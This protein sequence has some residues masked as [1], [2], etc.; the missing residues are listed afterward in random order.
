MGLPWRRMQLPNRPADVRTLSGR[1]V[2]NPCV[3]GYSAPM[4]HPRHI[5]LVIFDCDGVLVDSEPITNSIF[6]EMLRDLG[7]ALSA[8][9]VHEAFVGRSMKQCMEI[10]RELRGSPAPADFLDEYHRRTH[11]ALG[12]SVEAMPG[13]RKTIAAVQKRGAK[14]P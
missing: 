3:P 12:E 2:A 11:V 13:A 5:R 9:E 8:A 1:G 14:T 6:G 7:L 4:S 10:V